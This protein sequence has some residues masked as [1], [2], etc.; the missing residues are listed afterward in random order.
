M[1]CYEKAAPRGDN[2]QS[3]KR[4]QVLPSLVSADSVQETGRDVKGPAR[5]KEGTAA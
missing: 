2:T 1:N 5:A 4:E 3:G